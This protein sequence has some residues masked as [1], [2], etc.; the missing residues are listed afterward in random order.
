[1]FIVFVFFGKVFF[2]LLMPVVDNETAYSQYYDKDK[3]NFNHNI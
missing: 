3:N 2:L 1:M